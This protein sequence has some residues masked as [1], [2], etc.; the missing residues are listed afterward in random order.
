MTTQR[1]KDVLNMILNPL[2]PNK[3]FN[4]DMNKQENENEGRSI[5]LNQSSINLCKV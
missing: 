5:F 3:D 1:D 2:M 4:E